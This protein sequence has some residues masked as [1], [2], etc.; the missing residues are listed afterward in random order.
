MFKIINFFLRDKANAAVKERKLLS[1]FFFNLGNWLMSHYVEL[2]FS[3]LL[4]TSREKLL[5]SLNNLGGFNARHE[6]FE[7]LICCH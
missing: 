6:S 2:V 1:V 7:P 4:L 3:G 5:N